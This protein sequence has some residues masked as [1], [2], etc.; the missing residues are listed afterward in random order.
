[1]KLG[2][3]AFFA[4]LSGIGI[5]LVLFGS[6]DGA[7][8]D[9]AALHVAPAAP[10]DFANAQ[11]TLT[12]AAALL[13]R[14]ADDAR[15]EAFTL[16]DGWD[17]ALVARALEANEP[18]LRAFAR[19]ARQSEFSSRGEETPSELVAWIELAR[20]QG[21]RAIALARGGE[22]S[23]AVDAALV[24]LRVARVA[25]G[26]AG[27]SR[28]LRE[29]AAAMHDASAG[30]LRTALEQVALP[31]ELSARL[32]QE[33]AALRSD[34]VA[35]RAQLAAE[36]RSFAAVVRSDRAPALPA[37]AGG[38]RW[39]SSVLPASYA[40][41]P[42]NTLRLYANAARAQIEA[43][44]EACAGAQEALLDAGG[45]SALRPNAV[46]RHWIDRVGLLGEIR[47]TA[48]R[49]DTRLEALRAALGVQRFE[50]ERG[51]LPPSLDA[52]V[53]SY[54]EDA[55]RDFMQGGVLRLDRSA[56][57]IVSTGL[58]D[59]EPGATPREERFALLPPR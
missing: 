2:R 27:G 33:L 8:P 13:V 3:I 52:L 23:G 39:L 44:S 9:D 40:H 29:V 48:C 15:W 42:N 16:G 22:A 36:Y 43:A 55:P 53:S 57:E 47:R 45:I 25:A 6:R 4:L 54:L 56:R 12:S 31:P 58:W 28:L 46:G 7:P 19:A 49:A 32:A 14:D 38:V 41:Q 37:Q 30:A 10:D 51:A 20:L 59:A 35:V 18:A 17:E 34:P 1:M 24:G 5:A 11:I 50:H 21:V 26:G